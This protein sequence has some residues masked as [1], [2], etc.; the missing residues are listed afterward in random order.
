MILMIEKEIRGGICQVTHR[1]AKANNKYMKNYN[2]NIES[3]FTEYLDANNLYGWVMS[4]K[5][6]LNGFK[7][8]KQEELSNFNED[9][10]KNYDENGNIGYFL[11]VDIDYPK[12]LF[13]LHKDLPFLP[14]RKKVNKVE[15]LIC[16]IEDKEKYVMHIKVLKQALNHGLVF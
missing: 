7:W 1:Y 5:S 6:P 15:K 4:E 10:I 13:N 12:E 3:S 11:E 8:V 14:E 16:N 2:K 9:F